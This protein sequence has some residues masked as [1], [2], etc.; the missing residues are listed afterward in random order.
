MKRPMKYKQVANGEYLLR[1]K[2]KDVVGRQ[3][4][5]EIYLG[6]SHR[7]RY[8]M[9]SLLTGLTLQV[10]GNQDITKYEIFKLVEGE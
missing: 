9:K 6:N 8:T 7:N 4:V 2:D 3:D 10:D 1:S 5:F